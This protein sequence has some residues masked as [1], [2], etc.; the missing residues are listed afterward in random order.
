[1]FN[2]LSWN[3]RQGGGS[4]ASRIISCIRHENPDI[5][6]LNE[7]HNNNVGT[8]I[9]IA[10]LR[11]G[12]LHQV[13]S[14]SRVD[15]TVMIASKYPFEGKCRIS[16]D[17]VYPHNIILGAFDA[18]DVYGVYIPHKKKHKLFDDLIREVQA[19]GRPSIVVG[20]FNTGH[21]NIDQKGNSF[22]YQEEL[23]ALESIGMRDAFRLLHGSQ[24]MYSWYSP[25]GNGYRY[26]HSYISELLSSLVVRCEYLHLYRQEGASDHAPMILGLGL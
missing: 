16:T 2:I 26:D 19:S 4:R 9:R 24:E 18:F 11:M 12:Y 13:V 22:W 3:I 5:M 1:M 23:K 10:L 14:A 20:D 21:N 7:W 8:E 25:Q 15:N 17:R 6:A